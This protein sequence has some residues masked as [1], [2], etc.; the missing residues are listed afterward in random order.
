MV[1]PKLKFVQILYEVNALLKQN[2]CV[3]MTDWIDAGV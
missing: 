2:Q 3:M 1:I